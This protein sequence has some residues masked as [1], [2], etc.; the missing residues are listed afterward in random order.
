MRITF[1]CFIIPCWFCLLVLQNNANASPDAL[2][3]SQLR[4]STN[5]QISAQSYLDELI[6]NVN[7]S[8]L[9][10]DPQWRAL[11]HADLSSI[12]L[13]EKSLID[14]KAFFLSPNG[15]TDFH[16]ELLA[17]L[18]A[19]F[20]TEPMNDNHPQCKFPARFK[21]LK[22][23]LQIDDGQI[24]HPTCSELQEW[25]TAL[26]PHKLVLVFPS[27][28]LN[29]PAS[30]FGHTL[31][32]VDSLSGNSSAPLLSY[33]IN[34]SA[35]T[36][37]ENALLYAA[38]GIFGGYEGFFSIGPYYKKVTQYSDIENRDIWEYELKFTP[39]EVSFAILH[40]WEILSISFDYYYFDDNCS[41]LLLSFLNVMR[42]SLDLTKNLPPWVIPVDSIRAIA[43]NQS[44]TTQSMIAKKIFR[45]SNAT[46]LRH[47]LNESS[48]QV[49]NL[50]LDIAKNPDFKHFLE[51]NSSTLEDVEPSSL[52]D[53]LTNEQKAEALELAFERL[54][55]YKLSAKEV[56]K[57]EDRLHALAILRERS[58]IP[59]TLPTPNVPTPS[60]SPE[61][62]HKT[63]KVG[64]LVGYND[65]SNLFHEYN[66][67]PAYHDLLDPKEG[68]SLGS[69]IQFFDLRLRHE[70]ER[71]LSIESFTPLKIVSLSPKNHLMNPISWKLELS[72]E[73]QIIENQNDPMFF[74]S[75][76]K[77][78]QSWQIKNLISYALLGPS[79]EIAR[80]TKSDV[81]LGTSGEAGIIVQISNS[82]D[83]ILSAQANRF[84]IGESYS[85]YKLESTYR[86]TLSSDIALR[87]LARKQYGF[88]HSKL[89]TGLEV[90]FYM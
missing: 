74:L 72:F 89:E 84:S 23:K 9:H 25:Y 83:L 15:K 56:V 26:N 6:N 36:K 8:A 21:W 27:S 82:Q 49:K 34:Y 53:E 47:R 30:A 58:N 63:F 46:I 81:T 70:E 3:E 17:T 20:A 48:D 52:A 67:R 18:R 86:I 75:N 29:N 54:S 42:P 5:N 88:H 55:Y 78:G 1:Y 35:D 85:S 4:D 66:L 73:R 76:V 64:A 38:K 41:F 87:I 32:R 12:A 69:E 50:A 65:D 19:F 37:D 62:G 14:G 51:S 44:V 11:L 77:F 57:E 10:L 43:K 68:F 40:L 24:P 90:D 33:A 13:W 79:A 59:V 61:L 31:L 39:D 71:S 2:P 28:F 22:N 45:P 7:N 16:G 80:H 60:I